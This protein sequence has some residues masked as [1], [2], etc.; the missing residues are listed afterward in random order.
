[1][2]RRRGVRRPGLAATV[3]PEDALSDRL[4]H[5]DR[6]R[7]GDH[8]ASRRGKAGAGRSGRLVSSRARGHAEPARPDREP[9]DSPHALA[10]VGAAERAARDE[11]VG[12]RVRGRSRTDAR[13]RNG[14]RDTRAGAHAVEVLEPRLPAPR[15]DRVACVRHAIPQVHQREA[16]S[17]ARHDGHVP[18]PAPRPPACARVARL[19]TTHGSSPTSST[20]RHRK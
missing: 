15:R 17:P 3:R 11:L 1:M 9:D 2:G 4:D 6:H 18:R 14:D 8:A 13:P 19:V 7:D 16:P 5:Q 12:R 10:R 20:S